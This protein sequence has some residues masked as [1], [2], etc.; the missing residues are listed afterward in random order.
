MRVTVLQETVLGGACGFRLC[1]TPERIHHYR[2]AY[3]AGL[4]N[5]ASQAFQSI[6]YQVN[7]ALLFRLQPLSS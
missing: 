5:A 3:G 4:V 7:T 2:K 1:L 6:I